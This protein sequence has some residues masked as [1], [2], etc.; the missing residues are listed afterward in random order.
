MTQIES[1]PVNKETDN[2]NLTHN[3]RSLGE[4]SRPSESQQKRCE[5]TTGNADKG[6]VVTTNELNSLPLHIEGSLNGINVNMI[7]DSGSNVSLIDRSMIPPYTKLL[8]STVILT[9]ANNTRLNVLG[10]TK[11][12]IIIEG[13][14]YEQLVQVIQNLGSKVLLGNDF[15]INNKVIIDYD[16]AVIKMRMG[17]NYHILHMEGAWLRNFPDNNETSNCKQVFTLSDVR[18]KPLENVSMPILI[19]KGPLDLTNYEFKVCNDMI[20]KKQLFCYATNKE[21]YLQLKLTNL[22]RTT[23]TVLNNT[24]VGTVV[25]KEG[26]HS[27]IQEHNKN[28]LYNENIIDSDRPLVDLAGNPIDLNPNLPLQDYKKAKSLILTYRHIFA[29]N[30]E[31]IQIANISP[32]TFKMKSE[33]PIGFPP[34][35]LSKKERDEM[36]RQICELEKAG[37]IEKARTDYASPAFLVKKP[38]NKMRLVVNYTELNKNIVQDRF[39]LPRIDTILDTMEGSHFFSNMDINQAFFNLPLDPKCQKYTGFVTHKGLYVFKTCPMGISIA[40]QCFTRAMTSLFSD[41]LYSQGVVIYLD[42]VTVGSANFDLGLQRLENVFKRLEE[43]NLKIKTSKCHFMYEETKMFGFKVDRHGIQPL[44][45]RIEAIRDL[46]IPQTLKAVRSFLGVTSYYR[47]FIKN[48]ST[49]ASPLSDLTKKGEQGQNKK[50]QWGEIHQKAFDTLKDALTKPPILVH[51]SERRDTILRTDASY[52]GIGA[53]L[54]QIQ[55]DQSLKPVAYVSRKLSKNHSSWSASEIELF[56]IVYACHHFRHFLYGRYFE[57]QSDHSCLIYY[58]N[59]KCLTSRLN[60]LALKLVEFDFKI[61][62]KSGNTLKMADLLS[63]FPQDKDIDEPV[64]AEEILINMVKMVNIEKLQLED[65]HLFKIRMAI[66]DPENAENKYFRTARHYVL[67]DGILYRKLFTPWSSKQVI[68]LP[69]L[70]TVEVLRAY[71]DSLTGGAHSGIAKTIGKIKE[72]YYWDGMVKQVSEYVRNCFRCQVNKP[73]KQKPAGLLNPIIP[74]VQPFSDVTIDYVSPLTKSNKKEYILVAVDGTTRYVVAKAVVKADAKSTVDFMLN[75]LIPRFGVPFRIH[76][77]RGQH[78][79]AEVVKQLYEGLG[80]E[81]RVSTSYHPQSNGVCERYHST[82]MAMLKCYVNENHSDWSK[83]VDL[84]TFTYNTAVQASLGYSPFYLLH[85]FEAT[86]PIDLAILPKNPDH[87]VLSAIEELHK[88][89]KRI[90]EIMKKVQLKQKVRF[91]ESRREVLFKVGEEVLLRMP[92]RAGKG[93]R[94]L[95]ELYKGPFKITRIVSPV[96]YEL[97]LIKAGKWDRDVVH[98]DRL[99]KYHSSD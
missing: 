30:D 37:V 13:I 10:E 22:S 57:I 87:D 59:F 31:D 55:E 62:H 82:L 52:T 34:Y 11:V 76:S 2:I 44:K 91:D 98:V 14:V 95:A 15:L 96:N 16:K 4:E 84:V 56:A 71:H 24:L 97:E 51:F 47:K 88:I 66:I 41:L 85:G 53:E 99:K 89:R 78:F 27:Q 64:A 50:I 80:V 33:K 54:L 75:V 69:K 43:A 23:A 93:S 74:A 79:V 21:S 49:I 67:R 72:K 19:K 18:L 20:E 45:D 86:Q 92:F 42:D 26:H 48:Y 5:Y 70:L 60:R 65:P 17:N 6:H 1:K 28:M 38:N 12:R 61:V 9:A 32:C 83:Y 68:V 7:I 81:M 63:R 8:E 40:S 58:K 77:D 73:D 25:K 46:P 3:T 90:P 36:D 39:P 94:K 35:K 29:K